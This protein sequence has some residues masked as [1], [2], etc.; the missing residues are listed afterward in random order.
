MDLSNKGFDAILA[1]NDE[2]R[3]KYK[4]G[5]LTFNTPIKENITPT[6]KSFMMNVIKNDCIV[7]D[8]NEYNRSL[9]EISLDDI[10]CGVTANFVI[11]HM[12]YY[13]FSNMVVE[14]WKCKRAKI[15]NNSHRR[16]R[17]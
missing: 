15:F 9:K 2:L 11:T 8:Y 17:Q 6:A 16:R 1:N 7:Y 4:K 12:G 5:K 10:N 3:E 13:I 14:R